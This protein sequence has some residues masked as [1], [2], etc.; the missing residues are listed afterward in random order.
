MLCMI[1]RWWMEV[2]F[3]Q[4]GAYKSPGMAS[5]TYLIC[6]PVNRDKV[7]PPGDVFHRTWEWAVTGNS[8]EQ[9]LMIIFSFKT[10]SRTDEAVAESSPCSTEPG[11]GLL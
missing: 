11:N 5:G 7:G 9:S 1:S 8:I 2:G 3:S 10:V 4:I 6:F